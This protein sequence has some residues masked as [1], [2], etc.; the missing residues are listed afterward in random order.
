[1]KQPYRFTGRH[2]TAMLV[3]FFAVVIA[4]NVTMAIYAIEGF[5]GTVVENSYV[6]SQKFNGWLRAARNEDGLG[7]SER[8]SRR[9]DDLLV[10][11]LRVGSRPMRGA[12]LTAVA[13]HPLGRAD[14]ISLSFD[15][16]GNGQFRSTRK[17]PSGRWTIH[18]RIVMSGREKRFLEEIG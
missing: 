6:A 3:I 9:P 7:W 11:N 1:M 12:V 14:D 13:V 2:M 4:V 15:N 16:I 10:A 8:L 5:G 18:G 17:L